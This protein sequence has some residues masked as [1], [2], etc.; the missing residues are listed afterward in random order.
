MEEEDGR[1]QRTPTTAITSQNDA[2]IL[3]RNISKNP[4]FSELEV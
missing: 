4:N 3:K 1:V 2:M